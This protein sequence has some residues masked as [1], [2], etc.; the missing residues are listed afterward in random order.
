MLF[1]ATGFLHTGD[2]LV[3]GNMGLKDQSVALRWV[4]ENI[5]AFGG[6]RTRITIFGESAG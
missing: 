6:D 4:N 5:E 1:V 2:E 3:R